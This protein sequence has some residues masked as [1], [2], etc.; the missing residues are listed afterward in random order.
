MAF[1]VYPLLKKSEKWI[2]KIK[3]SEI[4]LK[5]EGSKKLVRKQY[6]TCSTTGKPIS[7]F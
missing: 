6:K 7:L 4:L 2:L 1:I 5:M 3:V